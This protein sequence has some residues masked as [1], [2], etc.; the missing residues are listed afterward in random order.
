M[1]LSWRQAIMFVIAKLPS[2]TINQ[3]HG[4]KTESEAL[5]MLM[6]GAIS[7]LEGRD[8]DR[9]EKGTNTY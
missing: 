5:R 4:R 8:Y 6:D 9:F 7:Q 1:L 2:D 3:R